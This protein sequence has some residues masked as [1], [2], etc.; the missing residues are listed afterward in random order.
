M[1][2]YGFHD[3]H[4]CGYYRVTM[5]LDAL[6]E[7]GGAEIQTGVGFSHDCEAFPIIVG[8]RIG[9]VHALTIWRDLY[10][11]HKLVYECDDDVWTIDSMNL[12]AMAQHKPE[13]LD[14]HETAARMAHMVTVTTEPLAEVFRQ[15]NS[16][17]VILP[18]HVDGRILELERPRAEK[19]VVGWAGGD[20]HYRDLADLA[21]H[22][23]RFLRRNPDTVEFHNMGTNFL[24]AFKVPGRFTDWQGN[25]FDYYR[26]VD[27][28]IG[29]APLTD[30]GFNRSKSGIKAIEYM[31]LGIPVIA[32]DVEP[33]RGIVKHGVNGFLVR[34]PHEWGHYLHL[35]AT[36]RD[37]REKMGREGRALVARQWTIQTGWTLWRD[38]YASLLG[39][40]AKATTL[41]EAPSK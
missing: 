26:K 20:S 11:G 23:A 40:S 37:L 12:S 29:L 15:F 24:R 34:Q 31:G 39:S 2:V 28:D 19:L 5:P 18:N 6:A 14:A 8:Q 25:M 32:S 41:Q 21:P 3:G 35:L 22:L 13:I 1:K 10:R 30:T 7:L 36:D 17:V 9:Q 38:A 27:F 4:A 33:Y 16:N